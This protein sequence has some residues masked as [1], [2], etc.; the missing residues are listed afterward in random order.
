MEGERSLVMPGTGGRKTR[1]RTVA[2]PELNVVTGAFGYCG[3]YIARVLVDQ[4]KRVRT[5]TGHPDRPNP[6]GAAVEAAPFNFDHPAALI[7][8]LRGA[9]TLYNTYWVRFSGGGAGFEQ[10]V[11]NSRALIRAAAAA[12]VR[13]FVH[14]SITNPSED[15]P[16]PYFRGKAVIERTLITSGLSYAIIRPTV[17]FGGEDIL[18]NNIA[19]LLRRLRAFGVFGAGDYPVQPVYVEDLAALAVKMA[20]R[21]ESLV[22]DAVGP[23]IYTFDELVRLI[24]EHVGSRSRIIHM[25][26]WLA[27]AAG[28]ALGWLVRDVIIT[29]DEISGLM[30]GLLRSNQA[31]TCPTRFSAWLRDHAGEIGNHYRSELSR[32]YRS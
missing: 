20:E 9:A 18:I 16:F 7:E 2:E 24:R 14:I 10:A 15:S 17:L 28:R 32:H 30:A 27:L 5:L 26:P 8:N 22:L 11:A 23:E 25:P 1:E 21:T 6:F 4:G 31:P 13:R 19:W 3:R 29:C 12:G